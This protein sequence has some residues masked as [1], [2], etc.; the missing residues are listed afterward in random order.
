MQALQA[1]F[2]FFFLFCRHFGGRAVQ[3]RS[4]SGLRSRGSSPQPTRAHQALPAG[5]GPAIQAGIPQ[6]GWGG[7][8]RTLSWQG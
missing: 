5:A 4:P 1:Q 7:S 8:P 6:Q 2:W 3:L